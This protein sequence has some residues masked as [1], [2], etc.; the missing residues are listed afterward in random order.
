MVYP[1][2][3]SIRG[4]CCIFQFKK[5]FTVKTLEICYVRF[6]NTVNKSFFYFQLN[7]VIC[8]INEDQLYNVW[9]ISANYFFI[10]VKQVNSESSDFVLDSSGKY[11][12][13]DNVNDPGY[14][15]AESPVPDSAR[16]SPISVGNASVGKNRIIAMHAMKIAIMML[17]SSIDY[18]DIK[19][20]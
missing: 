3:L 11:V 8:R 2:D 18:V 19:D 14:R 5:K 15:P 9:T 17:K 16:S 10:I 4:I 20:I 6:V 1:L 7:Q 12:Q 13:Y